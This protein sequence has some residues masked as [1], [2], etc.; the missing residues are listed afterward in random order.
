MT[1]IQE[2][3]KGTHPL[4]WVAVGCAGVIMLGVFVL[5]VGGLFVFNKTK[6]MV[7]EMD[8]NPVVAMA[9]IIAAANP[10]IELIEADEDNRV[11]T[12][13][14]TRTGEEYTIDFE[15]IEEDK[16]SLTSPMPGRIVKILVKQGEHV[17]KGQELIIIE[18]MKME[19]KICAPY[20]GTVTLIYFP[21]GDQIEANIPLMEIKEDEVEEKS[22]E[23][24]R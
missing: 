21:E 6:D 1:D 23:K 3:K 10:E 20:D 16:G 5:V 11:V 4:V 19:N 8:E 13:R 7:K 17:K 15:D 14:N 18:A 24:E 9:K 2:K 12:F 22:K